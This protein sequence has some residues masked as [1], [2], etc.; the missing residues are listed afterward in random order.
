MGCTV[1]DAKDGQEALR[2]FVETRD[3]PDPFAAV[4][5]DLTVPGGMG[6]KEAVREL[7]KVDR[8]IAI[9]A[10]SGYSEDP[11]MSDPEKFGFTASIRK[12]YTE[13]E[14]ARLLNAVLGK[15]D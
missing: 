15:S 3:S 12:P 6:G 13:R 14:L 10:S 5:L 7:R 1:V 8:G 11:I 4:I 9:V 2:L